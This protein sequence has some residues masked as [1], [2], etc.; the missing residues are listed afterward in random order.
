M[1]N[2][3]GKGREQKVFKGLRTG[4]DSGAKLNQNQYATRYITWRLSIIQ[5]RIQGLRSYGRLLS[6]P[7]LRINNWERPISPHLVIT[8][9]RKFPHRARLPAG[10]HEAVLAIRK[11]PPRSPREVLTAL[12]LV[13]LIGLSHSLICIDAECHVRCLAKARPSSG[14]AS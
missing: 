10:D 4:S 9:R 13:Y 12:P 1:K 7:G 11:T 8:R 14:V 5:S 2:V 3:E 6:V